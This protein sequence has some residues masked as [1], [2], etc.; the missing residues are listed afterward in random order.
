[1]AV[2]DHRVPKVNKEKGDWME[3]MDYQ[4]KLVQPERKAIAVPLV[5]LDRKDSKVCPE[6]KDLKVNLAR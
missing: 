4:E 6:P 5:K 3:T 1:M 2:L